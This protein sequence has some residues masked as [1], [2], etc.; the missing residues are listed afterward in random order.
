MKHKYSMS[1]RQTREANDRITS[2]AAQVGLVYH[3]LDAERGNTFNAH[4]LI[5]LAGTHG[6]ADAM[7]ERLMAAYFTESQPIGDWATLDSWRS[8]SGSAPTR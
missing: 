6:I 3:L 5:H 2:A 7:E 8:K 4:R 1:D